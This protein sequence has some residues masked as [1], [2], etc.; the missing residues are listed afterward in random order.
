MPISTTA[1]ELVVH[2]PVEARGLALG[3]LATIAIASVFALEWAQQL[4]VPLLLGILLNDLLGKS[5][6]VPDRY[7]PRPLIRRKAIT[8]TA[9]T[10]NIWMKPPMV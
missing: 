6:S 5:E 1:R 10:N 7:M 4:L 8:T 3:I 2:I 9:I